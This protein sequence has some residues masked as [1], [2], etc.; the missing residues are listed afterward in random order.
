[1]TKKLT[2]IHN[3]SVSC[4]SQFISRLPCTVIEQADDVPNYHRKM[5]LRSPWIHDP[6]TQWDESM[7]YAP[8]TPGSFQN[9]ITNQKP[10]CI[11]CRKWAG[12][13]YVSSHPLHSLSTRISATDHPNSLTGTQPT[14]SSK[15]PT[16]KPL[17][18]SQKHGLLSLNQA[19]K[20]RGRGVMNVDQVFG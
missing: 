10:D 1:M 11:D 15:L 19:R 17:P 20:W 12:A 14:S 6:T 8:N 3:V 2:F 5:Q 7:P 4:H 13:M 9:Q 18:Q 16:S